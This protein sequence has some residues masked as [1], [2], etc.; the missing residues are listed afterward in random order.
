M[1]VMAVFFPQ[2][3]IERIRIGYAVTEEDWLWL[4]SPYKILGRLF[5]AF[6]HDTVEKGIL[7]LN[8]FYFKCVVG[9]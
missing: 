6:W 4:W 3:T 7:I 5:K 8:A 1:F 9:A 2:K